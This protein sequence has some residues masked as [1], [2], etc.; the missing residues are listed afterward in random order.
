MHESISRKTHGE[1]KDAHR[2]EGDECEHRDGDPELCER[3]GGDE[4]VIE[5]VEL[6]DET[7]ADAEVD[8]GEEDHGGEDHG[9]SC[10]EETHSC[11]SVTFLCATRIEGRK[12]SE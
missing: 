1:S 9:A 4:P 2:A 5:V 3:R 10:P 11:F 8:D 7:G 6:G 12:S